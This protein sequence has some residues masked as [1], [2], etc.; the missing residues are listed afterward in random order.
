MRSNGH[1]IVIDRGVAISRT[2]SEMHLFSVALW[3]DL[4]NLAM[5]VCQLLMHRGLTDAE[6]R[7]LRRIALEGPSQQV[8]EQLSR[9]LPDL[10]IL[11]AP[12]ALIELLVLCMRPPPEVT[13][14]VVSNPLALFTVDISL[15]IWDRYG[16]NVHELPSGCFVCVIYQ[17]TCRRTCRRTLIS[18][19]PSIVRFAFV[20]SLY[21]Y[22]IFRFVFVLMFWQ[23]HCL[24]HC[25]LLDTGK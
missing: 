21:P 1:C 22:L 16:G 15:T 3:R 11:K 18:L 8:A 12:Q 9:L 2:L 13:K 7:T 6:A 24:G 23:C 25:G 10:P 20:S 17:Q 5:V 4:R 14:A 19:L